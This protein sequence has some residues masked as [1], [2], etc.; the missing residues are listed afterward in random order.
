MDLH[1]A[2][3]V[4]DTQIGLTATGI[5]ARAPEPIT[6]DKVRVEAVTV[7]VEAQPGS[8]VALADS[9]VHALQ[10]LRGTPTLLGVNDLSLPP[11]NLLGAIGLPLIV[12]A[13]ALQALHRL[14]QRRI[15]HRAHAPGHR[16]CRPK[17]NRAPNDA[18][19][20]YQHCP[21]T[22]SPTGRSPTLIRNACR[23]QPQP[24]D[25]SASQPAGVGKRSL[26]DGNRPSPPHRAR[27]WGPQRR[28]SGMLAGWIR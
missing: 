15:G 5:R 1:A 8:A 25:S 4:T 13:I 24:A 26:T 23:R 19:M 14:R 21:S 27:A 18:A 28:R 7:G 11:L 22:T 17:P 3:T 2:T 20:S 6:L 16:P 10:A 9:T 12:L